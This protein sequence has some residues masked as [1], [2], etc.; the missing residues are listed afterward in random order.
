MIVASRREVPQIQGGR[1]ETRVGRL[2]QYF[3]TFFKGSAAE[4]VFHGGAVEQV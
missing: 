1:R 4:V 3:E 2:V